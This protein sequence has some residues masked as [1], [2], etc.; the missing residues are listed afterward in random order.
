MSDEHT[1]V[2]DFVAKGDSPDEWKMVLVEEGPW[3][4]PIDEQLRRIQERMYGCIDAALDGQLAESFP[5][6]KGKRVIVQLDCYNVP[7]AEVEDFFQ[8]FSSGVLTLE[9]YRE[10]LERSE[11]VEGLG[12][13]ISFDNIH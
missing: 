13:N 2:V 3:V 5:D 10:A 1:T 7:R 9:D 4:G 12:F 6:S 8:R 11:F